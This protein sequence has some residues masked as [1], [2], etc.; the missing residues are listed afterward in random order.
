[1]PWP[2]PNFQFSWGSQSS[3]TPVVIPPLYD[4]ASAV[5]S[6]PGAAR[7]LG[8]GQLLS[9]SEPQAEVSITGNAVVDAEPMPK[10]MQPP[11]TGRQP[12]TL[13]NDHFRGL[14]RFPR[15]SAPKFP[16]SGGATGSP[17]QK[18]SSPPTWHFITLAPEV[19]H[20]GPDCIGNINGA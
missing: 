8:Q 1:M 12:L 3:Q 6:G 14:A 4:I 15:S 9:L 16:R 10:A 17:A 19:R 5:D 2:G 18:H 11:S 13:E 20:A 7:A